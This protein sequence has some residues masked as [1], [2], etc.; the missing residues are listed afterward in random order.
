MAVTE[1]LLPKPFESNLLKARDIVVA[2]V[3]EWMGAHASHATIGH[4]GPVTQEF[5]AKQATMAPCSIVTVADG[6]SYR[7]GHG[8]T[9]QCVV[10]WGWYIVVRGVMSDRSSNSINFIGEAQRFIY[11][12]VFRDADPDKIFSKPP[13]ADSV[14]FR[15]RYLDKDEKTAYTVYGL[16]WQQ[17][18]SLGAAGRER[19]GDGV[20]LLISG[21]DEY[22]G[23]P[24]GDEV[25]FEVT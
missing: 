14:R 5:I 23:E 15:S 9:I 1:P 25:P 21:T 12:D 19:E 13:A 7:L 10:T 11:A 18:I 4:M 20:L 8:M 22:P 6:Q 2:Q 16:Q 24:N 3:Q 17:E